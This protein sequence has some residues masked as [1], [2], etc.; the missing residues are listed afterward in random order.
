MKTYI[1]SNRKNALFVGATLLAM[2]GMLFLA[3]T[4]G[5]HI[6]PAE[7]NASAIQQVPAI[8]PSG[9]VYDGDTVT[10]TVD[11]SNTATGACDV[12]EADAEITLP[13]GSVINVLVDEDVLAGETINCPG[14]PECAAGP[15]TYIVDHAD[16]AGGLVTTDFN[17]TG[18][19]HDTENDVNTAS[20][21][22][23]LSKLVIHPS[24]IT[25][26]VSDSGTVVSGG[27]V[28]LTVTE[29]N[30][31]DVDLTNVSVEVDNGVGT[32]TSPPDSGDTG[33]DNVLGV[34]ETW[35]W[36]VSSGA[37]SSNTTFTA[38]GHGEDPNGNDVTW[39]DGCAAENPEENVICDSDEEDEVLVEV[40]ESLVVEKTVDES[41]DREW[42]WDIAKSADDTELDPLEEGQIHIVNYD[43]DVSATSND[44]SHEVTGTITIT[45]PVGNPDATVDSV[46]DV[47]D[48]SGA[49]SVSC[50]DADADTA[51][52]WTL[53]PGEVLNCTYEQLNADPDDSTNTATVTTSGD[54]PG[55]EAVE[56]VSFGE[57]DLDDEIDECVDVNDTNIGFLGTVCANEAPT[58]FEYSLEFSTDAE[59]DV[60]LVCGDNE[61]MNI[62]DL[63]TN[64]TQTTDEDDEL[65]TAFV[66]C[67]QGCT[68]TQGY[69]KTHSVLGPAPYDSEGWGNLGDFDGN[70]GEEEE[71]EDWVNWSID[72][73]TAFWTPPK[74][75]NV[76]YKL[77]HQ[78][79]AAYLNAQNGA[80]T[81]TEVD[82]ALADAE[83]WLMTM[84]PDDKT[85]GK[86]A[87]DANSWHSTLAS[88]NEG[89]IG[90]GHCDEDE[91]SEEI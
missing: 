82:D 84:N 13:D 60:V 16:E 43:V 44:V 15:Y 56:P 10:Y 77:A 69:W 42:A 49:A 28:T 37:I 52:P 39:T 78:F 20:D 35:S 1:L 91:T 63:V 23:Q 88:Y 59:A 34:G 22:D 3:P 72:W 51:A 71:G 33:G 29:E 75:G 7:C 50:E 19:L 57:E 73:Y 58:T 70:E 90:P 66:D 26:I 31:G 83:N 67:D 62:A 65:V 48:V 87:K 55:G 4:A 38:V 5:A 85:K 80:S 41:F 21:S 36:D 32:L 12:T 76:W 61:H 79:Q 81:P 30:N 45:N 46:S 27:S 74:G 6:S 25:T 11:Y 18:T 14:D 40:V 47:L 64:D 2:L 89:D 54:V 68:L 24:T 17:I 9:P 8:G 86:D 53:S